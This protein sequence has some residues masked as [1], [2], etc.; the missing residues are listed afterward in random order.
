M[1]FSTNTIIPKTIWV[2]WWQG[3]LAMP[4]VIKECY[5]S[6]LRNCNGRTVVLLDQNNF[7]DYITLPDYILRKFYEGVISK[8]HFSDIL[9]V[10]LLKEYGGMWIDAAIF[11]K[12]NTLL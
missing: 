5:K 11:V 3:E 4:P 2:F 7:K 12:T 1:V 8:T 10:G 6:I 9:R